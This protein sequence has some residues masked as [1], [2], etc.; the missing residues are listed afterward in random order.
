MEPHFS[1]SN[2][3]TSSRWHPHRR[4]RRR[5]RQRRRTPLPRLTP[6]AL[7][8]NEIGQSVRNHRLTWYFFDHV[9]T[10]NRMALLVWEGSSRDLA[11]WRI[12]GFWVTLGVALGA[13]VKW[14]ERLLVEQEVLGSIPALYYRSRKPHF[15]FSLI[16]MWNLSR[17]LDILHQRRRSIFSSSQHFNQEK[18]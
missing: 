16:R 6:P 13:L 12:R 15:S 10:S 4:R 7:S 3:S 5:R 11:R 18:F 14:L 1:S 8:R 17:T 9:Q 2:L